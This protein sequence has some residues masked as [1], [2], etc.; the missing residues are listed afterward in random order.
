MWRKLSKKY[1]QNWTTSPQRLKQESWYLASLTISCIFCMMWASKGA[2]A[3]LTHSTPPPAGYSLVRWSIISTT[4]ESIPAIQLATSITI[5]SL[6][7]FLLLFFIH[8][9]L[10][11]VFRLRVLGFSLSLICLYYIIYFCKSQ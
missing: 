6:Q 1:F 2:C 4:A 7:A 5:R 3:V 11:F 10:L 9:P 8:S